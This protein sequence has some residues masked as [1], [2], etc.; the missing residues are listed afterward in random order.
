VEDWHTAIKLYYRNSH[1]LT[2]LKNNAIKHSLQS[3]ILIPD[4]EYKT[5]G[6][7]VKG[8]IEDVL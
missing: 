4:S 6:I 5:K 1:K 8:I 7:A 2:Q 3:F